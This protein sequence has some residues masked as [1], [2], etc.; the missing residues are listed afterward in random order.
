MQLWQVYILLLLREE[1]GRVVT[2]K[3]LLD[4]NGIRCLYRLPCW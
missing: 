2:V 4:M 3:S 1:F